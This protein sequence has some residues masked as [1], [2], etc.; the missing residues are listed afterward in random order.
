MRCLITVIMLVL[1]LGMPG[2][3]MADN[4]AQNTVTVRV[5]SSTEL[6]LTGSNDVGVT[7]FG[8]APAVQTDS[9]ISIRWASSGP[10]GHAS[11][12]TAKMKTEY[13]SGTVCQAVLARP[14]DSDAISTGWKDLSTYA[15][16]MVTGIG[17]ENCVGATIAYA[18][19]P[20]ETNAL[21]TSQI[22]TVIWTI[23]ST[24]R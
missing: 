12:I 7:V 21:P 17:N 5:V 11:K 2:I 14:I 20:L 3:Q 1:L 15:V 13:A 6:A 23:T 19:S 24:D 22:T 16:D 8:A 4:S 18:L 10:T 9:L